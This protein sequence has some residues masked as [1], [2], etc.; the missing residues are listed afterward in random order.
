MKNLSTDLKSDIFEKKSRLENTREILKSEFVGL[1]SVI[2]DLIE[3]FSYWFYFPKLQK[4]PVVINL[5]GLT[6]VGKTS[7]INRLIQH[8]DFSKHFYP[9]NLSEYD[10]NIKETIGELYEKQN[11]QDFIML[12]DEFQNVRTINE[13]GNERRTNYQYLWEL[14]DTGKIPLIQYSYQLNEIHQLQIK[15]AQLLHRGVIATNGMVE[16]NHAIYKIEMGLE[17]AGSRRRHMNVE[18]S[19]LFFVPEEFHSSIFE[20][21]RE[22]FALQSDVRETLKT[23]NGWQTVEFLKKIVLNAM[24]TKYLDCSHSLVFIVGNLDEAYTMS[25]NFDTD[26]SANDF[27]EQSLKITL[28]QIKK[29]L[30]QRFRSEQIA[31]LGNNHIIYPSLNEQSFFR[32]I[33]LELQKI[34]SEVKY[35]FGIHLEF[36]DTVSQL[37]YNEG[38]YPTQG[39]RP[40]FSTIHQLVN[41]QIPKIIYHLIQAEASVDLVK[42][43]FCNKIMNFRFFTEG[44]EVYHFQERMVLNLSKLRKNKKDEMQA[45]C[46]VHESGHAVLSAVL[47]KCIPE[48]IYSSTSGSDNRGFVYTKM[49]WEYISKGEIV[50]RVAVLLGGY[51]AER[52]VFGPENL[53]NGSE[54]DIKKA[55]KFVCDLLKNCGMGPIPAVFQMEDHTTNLMIHDPEYITN[56]QAMEIISAGLDCAEEALLKQKKLLLKMSEYL[57]D[58]RNMMKDQITQL[59]GEYAVDME[60]SDIENNGESALYRK[61]LKQQLHFLEKNTDEFVRSVDSIGYSLNNSQSLSSEQN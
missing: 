40:L 39:T 16:G 14:L 27:H 61:L 46:A 11:G 42:I 36:E 21:Y 22:H 2:D 1:D 50:D 3:S 35:Q 41:T 28:P 52:L 17:S 32:L 4:K 57:A 45:I 25:H 26:I 56:T 15:L 47:L 24:S 51:A 10:R 33:E 13:E 7:L 8:L 9:F 48:I 20:L 44:T 43:S 5:W 49:R 19:E 37:L 54:S 53:T 58:N 59:V 12:F 6:G 55:T 18:K 38:V 29:A 23:M 30:K 31:R 60:L 34:K